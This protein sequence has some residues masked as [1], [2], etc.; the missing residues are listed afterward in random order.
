M[1]GHWSEQG[2]RSNRLMQTLLVW[3]ALKLGRRSARLILYPTA[4][5]FLLFHGSARRASQ[6]YLRKVLGRTPR[7]REVFQH[8]LT[9]GTVSVDRLFFLSGRFEEFDIAL[10]GQELF[11]PLRA[12]QQ[13]ALLLVAHLGSFDAMR[14]LG[15]REGTLPL[16]IVLD[17]RH[18]ARAATLLDALDPALA[19][20]I[21]DAGRPAPELVLALDDCLKNGAMVGIMADRARRDERVQAVPFFGEPAHFPL[22]PWQ[23]ALSLKVP[24]ILCCGLY[25][26][27]KRYSLHFETLSP[28][29]AAA[30]G[31]RGEVLGRHLAHYAARLEHYARLAPYNWFNF[32]D[33]W[34]H[35]APDD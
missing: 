9:F 17:R 30:R 20:N 15:A 31:Q 35:A 16:K 32:Y 10:A 24:V 29:I 5:Y 7:W 25:R 14:V 13:G 18:N 22:G 6:N 11:G 34:S 12:N 19:A 27:G 21:I 23:L 8:F 26:G 4:A 1:N 3:I 2:E 33:F 28:G